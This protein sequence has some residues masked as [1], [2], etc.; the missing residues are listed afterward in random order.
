M[1]IPDAAQV[2]AL[3]T[4]NGADARAVVSQGSGSRRPEGQDSRPDA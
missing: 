1:A 4:R 3:I 2:A